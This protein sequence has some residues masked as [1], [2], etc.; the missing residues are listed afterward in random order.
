MYDDGTTGWDITA[1]D[2]IWTIQYTIASWHPQWAKF[3]SATVTDSESETAT[4]TDDNSILL[5]DNN[6]P[7]DITLSNATVDENVPP[8]TTVGTFATIDID[9]W[10]NHTYSFIAGAWDIDNGSFTITGDILSINASPDFEAQPIY[11]IRVKTDDGN[12][13]MYEKEFTI[14]IKDL[15]EVPPVI[16]WTNFSS[17][18]LLPGGSHD[19]ILNYSDDSSGIDSSSVTMTLHKWDGISTWGPNIAGT[20]LTVGAIDNTQANYSINNIDLWK[21]QY[22]FTLSDNAGNTTTENIDFYID[23][24]EFIVSTPEINIWDFNSFS[25]VFSP[26]VQITV[27]TVGAAFELTMNADNNISSF[28]NNIWSY[29]NIVWF[30]YQPTPFIGNISTIES[31][32]NIATQGAAINTNG[33]QNIYLYEIQLGGIIDSQQV[34]WEYLGNIDF[35]INLQY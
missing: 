16:S 28:G 5:N 3:A 31:D 12:W 22:R 14:N 15:D 1:N 34:A 29:D 17:W 26:T 7:T 9:T 32:E 8:N 11:S 24:P 33:D 2:N 6:A 27:K 35:D 18:S 13:G 25:H 19:I 21:Y 23:I 30:G 10:D 4:A 20:S